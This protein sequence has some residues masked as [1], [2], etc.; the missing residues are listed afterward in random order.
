M[1]TPTP[2]AIY[3]AAVLTTSG[4]LLLAPLGLPFAGDLTFLCGLVVL[5]S[6][7]ACPGSA[8]KKPVYVWAC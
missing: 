4:L 6:A 1:N 3:K 7:L 2:L 5:A 8:Y